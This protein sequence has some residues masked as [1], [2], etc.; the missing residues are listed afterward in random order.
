MQAHTTGSAQADIG[1][2]TGADPVG[3]FG[4]LSTPLAS[5]IPTLVL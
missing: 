4:G 1:P 3:G 2:Y 5:R